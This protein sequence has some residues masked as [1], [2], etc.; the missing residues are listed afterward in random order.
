LPATNH[1]KEAVI[2]RNEVTKN[3]GGDEGFSVRFF[4]ETALSTMRFFAPLRMT[5]GE[6]LRM[7]QY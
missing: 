5:R 6:G 2:L 1:E 3:L 4:V 7:T